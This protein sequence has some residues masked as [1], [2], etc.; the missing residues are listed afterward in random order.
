MARGNS[1]HRQARVSS[2]VERLVIPP[3]PH[4]RQERNPHA[5]FVKVYGFDFLIKLPVSVLKTGALAQKTR[6]ITGFQA[7]PENGV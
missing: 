3:D 2:L 5:V 4:G 1:I 6:C 7:G